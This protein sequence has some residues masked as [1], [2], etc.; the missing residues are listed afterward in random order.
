MGMTGASDTTRAM[1]ASGNFWD[2]LASYCADRRAQLH[3]IFESD[4][5]RDT[6][7]KTRGAINEVRCLLRLQ[8]D[9]EDF[10]HSTNKNPLQQK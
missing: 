8:Q 6:D 5:D 4:N 7:C 3:K 10:I 2:G 1:L 9:V